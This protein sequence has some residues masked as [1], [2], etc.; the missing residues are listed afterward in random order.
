MA[1]RNERIAFNIF[2]ND[3]EAGKTIRQLRQESRKLSNEINNKLTPGTK[4][5]NREVKRLSRL[6]RQIADHRKKVRGI[7]SSWESV[8]KEIRSFGLIAIGALGAQQLFQ[9]IDNLIQRNAQLD[10]SYRDVAKTTGLT[11]EQ[12]KDLSSELKK[13]DTRTARRDLLGLAEVAGKLGKS[14]EK[15]IIGFVRAADRINVALGKDLGG[16]IETTIRQLGKI[17]QLFGVEGDFGTEDG[18][19]K[20][21]SAINALGAASTA[22]EQFLVEFTKRLGG[23]AAQ[24]GL[25]VDQVLGLG[26]TLDQLGQTSEVSTTALSQLLVK[27]GSE[28]ETF[29]E[30]AGTS[31]EE[32]SRL[33]AEDANAALLAVFEG[34][35]N[36]KGGVEGLALTLD[37][38]GIDG[39]RAAGVLGALTNNTDLLR[40]QQALASAEFEKGTSIIDE[41]NQKNTGLA[42]NIDKLRKALAGKFINSGVVNALSSLVNS[43]AKYIEIPVSKKLE[44]E[45][46]QLQSLVV[47]VQLAGDNQAERNKLLQELQTNYPQYFSNLDTEID[48]NRQLQKRMNQANNAFIARIV[49]ARKEEDI[50]KQAEK[51]ASLA[52][53]TVQRNIQLAETI[54]DV[55]ERLREKGVEPVFQLE[56]EATEEFLK[57]LTRQ[58]INYNASLRQNRNRTNELTAA[59]RL[60]QSSEFALDNK[61]EEISD[62]QQEME[63]LKNSLK[64][65][66]S[67]EEDFDD[68]DIDRVTESTQVNT[69]VE[70][71]VDNS[72]SNQDAE[73]IAQREAAIER[74]NETIAKYR[75]ENELAQLEADE[76]ELEQIR[77]KYQGL[78]EEAQKYD[79]S[80]R[81]IEAL[82]DEEL[83]L[84]KQEFYERDLAAF[85]EFTARLIELDQALREQ[86]AEINLNEEESQLEK[87]QLELEE[88][89]LRYQT[90]L[91]KLVAFKDTEAVTEQQYEDTLTQIKELAE[92]ERAI[93]E[94]KYRQEKQ[95]KDE[96]LR[97]LEIQQELA[98]RNNLLNISSSFVN[99][100]GSLTEAI[101]GQSE[102]FAE[103]QKALT[104][105]QIGIDTAKAISGAIAQAQSVPFPANLAAIATGVAA[106]TANIARAKQ[107]FSQAG[108]VP[109]YAEGGAT[110]DLFQNNTG[111]PTF[112]PGGLLATPTLAI[113]GEKGPEYIVPNW[114]L[115]D[116][117]YANMVKVLEAG[118]RRGPKYYA[119]GGLT[120]ENTNTTSDD[121]STT[122]NDFGLEE[123]DINSNFQILG[124]LSIVLEQLN[125]RLSTPISAQISNDQLIENEQRLSEIDENFQN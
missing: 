103:F 55:Q 108:E 50:Q 49:L 115:Q 109:R 75:A 8:K 67:L 101:A 36:T 39:S 78:I 40:E 53:R 92:G 70:E 7:S 90:F 87:K 60:L 107:V 91:E 21:G 35:K 83:G 62:L 73:K 96:E 82:R 122:I 18:L 71:S 110:G 31:T 44:Q 74:L 85:E 121:L 25:T 54:A 97:K 72:T 14:G 95:K 45:R 119:E 23:V 64:D 79:Q 117:V 1:T 15:D 125:E 61:R 98:H 30:I 4:E 26:A 13:I 100:F 99:A 66:L 80:I 32:F 76:R 34:S 38:L 5:Y 52:E 114:Q 17:S 59:L 47:Q 56:G 81:E 63:T 2:I 65:V 24:A 6:N 37:Q 9:G 88:I 16:N 104:L 41:F 105:F 58:A 68:S 123:S 33:L 12:V 113:A 124:Q 93:I 120:G 48:L 42:A 19:T 3:R 57:R 10:D 77:I 112:A 22:N 111:L 116:P 84:K 28:I 11:V 20:I 94:E 46:L 69:V 27:I 118:R 51:A 102:G 29:A 89:D 86:Q 106:V 43:A